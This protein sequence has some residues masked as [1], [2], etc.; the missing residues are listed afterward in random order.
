MEPEHILTTTQINKLTDL[1]QKRADSRWRGDFDEADELRAELDTID[2]PNGYFVSLQDVP[3]KHGGGSSWS[4]VRNTTE[5]VLEGTTVLQLAH[6]ALGLALSWSERQLP[7]P[8][9]QLQELI[10]QANN[11]LMLGNAVEPELRGRKAAD[12]AFWF[13]LAGAHD[14]VLLQS[15]SRICAKELGRFGTRNSCRGKDVWHILERLAAAGIRNDADLERVGKLALE[16]KSEDQSTENIIDFHSDRCLLMIWKFSTKQRKQRAFLEAALKHWERQATQE[17][18][19]D[20]QEKKSNQ[21]VWQD[22]YADPTKPLVIDVGC[23]MGVSLLGLAQQENK[24][25]CYNGVLVENWSN[26]N[27]AGVDLSGLAIGFGQSIS[28]RWGLN[29]RLHFFADEAESFVRRV[30]ETYPGPV[31]LC[32][33]QFPTPYRLPKRLTNDVELALGNSQLPSDTGSGFM[34]NSILLGV[35]HQALLKA[36]GKLLVQSNCEDVALWMKKTAIETVGFQAVDCSF[37]A[38]E[39]NKVPVLQTKRTLDWISMGGERAD[40]MT[41]S[42]G[43]ILPRKGR[44]ETEVACLLNGVPVHRCLLMTSV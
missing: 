26:C 38:K 40:G 11:R 10:Q 23:G 9:S 32:L 33:V 30:M 24:K 4:L 7:L 21:Y 29:D 22:I 15:L 6:A 41:W 19:N 35:I 27:L 8:P 28:K 13:S 5:M 34:V 39:S 36:N 20:P 18:P 17:S 25:S 44:T 31:E 12:S 43:P 42:K 16:S 37:V 3:R 14:E 1:V 2:L